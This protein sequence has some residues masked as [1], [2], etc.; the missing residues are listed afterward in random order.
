MKKCKLCG[1]KGY[2][3]RTCPYNSK[4]ING[5]KHNYIPKPYN[6]EN[7]TNNRL[8]IYNNQLQP[9]KKKNMKNGSWDKNG[10][11]SELD[12]GVHQICINNISTNTPGFSKKTGQDNWS[13]LRGINNHCVCLGAWSL[14][15]VNNKT[16]NK[17]N[18]LNCD[19]I[20][21]TVF[22]DRY[23]SSF[24][25]GWNKWKGLEINN[26]IIYGIEGLVNNCLNKNDTQKYLNLK[27]N[28]CNLAKKHES[29]SRRKLYKKHCN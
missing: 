20:P 14:Y 12:G 28:Y 13:D 23:T 10:K 9:C 3:I 17:N 15:N 1:L 24:S 6:Y 29:L 7:F 22:S 4:K 21:K 8:N 11:C 27:N 25:E 5:K 16:N 26:Q 2:N 19:A 18:V